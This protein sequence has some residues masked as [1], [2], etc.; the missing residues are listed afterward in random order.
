[1]LAYSVVDTLIVPAK[2]YQILHQRHPVGHRL[3][4][5]FAVG[6]GEY[7]FVVVAFGFQRRDAAVDGLHLHHHPCLAAEWVIVDFAVLVGSVVAQ[8]VDVEFHKTFFLSP[9][10]YGAVERRIEHF[11]Q[12]GKYVDTH[13]E[14]IQVIVF[15][16]TAYTSS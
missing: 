6:R 7:H 3:V 15:E 13:K 4:E 14:N 2:Y 12:Y 10:Q 1:M 11:G 5:A 8:V 16:V 9:L